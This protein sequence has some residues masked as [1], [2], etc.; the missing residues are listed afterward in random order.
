M[1]HQ[2]I[3]ITLLWNYT[4]KNESSKSSLYSDPTQ[5]WENRGVDV[6][7]IQAFN[8]PDGLV[9]PQQQGTLLVTLCLKND[10]QWKFLRILVAAVV[11][12]FAILWV[13]VRAQ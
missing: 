9:V 5:P 6:T 11:L 3:H 8:G 10:A 12:S 2:N 7:R 1:T 13:Q 4:G